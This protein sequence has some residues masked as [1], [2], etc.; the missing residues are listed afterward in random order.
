MAPQSGGPNRVS[1]GPPPS[2]IQTAPNLVAFDPKLAVPFQPLY[3]QRNDIIL[4]TFLTNGTNVSAIINYRWLTPA[5]EILEGQINPAPFGPTIVAQLTLYEGWLLS[6]GVRITSTIVAGQWTYL[7]AQLARGFTLGIGNPVTGIIWEGYVLGAISTGWPGT[8]PKEVIDGAG[9]LRSITG[10][11]PALGA[12]ISE[13]V[14]NNRRWQ[15]LALSA[16]IITS[17]SGGN[18]TP[19]LTIDDGTNLFYQSFGY[20]SSAPSTTTRFTASSV[21]PS[22][23]FVSGSLLMGV[24]LPFPLKTGF[25]IRSVT[26]NLQAG[27]QWSA[28]QYLVQEWGLWDG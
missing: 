3:M 19:T 16:T 5:G 25:R 27:D 17:A 9:T 2:P 6:F 21:V 24:P 18:R 11:T 20:S 10:A 15:L 26:L 8:V 7:Q 4:F 13:A 1:D 23:A 14:P 28:P 12:E 22:Q